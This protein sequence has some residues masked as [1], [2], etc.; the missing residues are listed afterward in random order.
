M[1]NK[2]EQELNN[3][4][5][6]LKSE[7]ITLKKDLKTKV[8]YGLTFERKTEKVVEEC[9]NKLPVLK[10][11]VGKKVETD[12]TK[13][14]N[15]LI[16]GDNYHSLQVLNYTHQNKVDFIYIDPPYNRGGD[17]IYN[18]DFIKKEDSYKHSMW[19]SFME[20]RLLLSRD[21]LSENGIIFISID[22][23]EF[24]PLKLLCDQIFT[25]FSSVG[26]IC[27]QKASGGGNAK[28]LVMGHEYIV[29]FS[30]KEN[31]LTQKN[32]KHINKNYKKSKNYLE[33]GGKIF[34]INDDII[35]KYFGKYPE[36]VE[37]RCEYEELLKYKDL[38][39]KKEIDEKIKNGE[40]ILRKNPNNPK[41]NFICELVEISDARMVLYSIIQNIFNS[42][43][44]DL[45]LDMG[46]AENMFDYPKPVNLIKI[47]LDS[48]NNKNS[49]V[50]DF[51]AGSGTTGHAVLELNKD[52]GNRQF[53][54][55]T[56]N[57]DEK[58]EHKIASDICYPR[59][60]KAIEGYVNKDKE[61][62]KGL[63]GNIRYFKT[64]FIDRKKNKD[65]MKFKITNVSTEIL[66]L[67][68]GIFDVIE[69]IGD[70]YS[71]TYKIVKGYTKDGPKVMGIYFDINDKKLD[72]MRKKLLKYKED[73]VAYIFSLS[74][75]TLDI[76][77]NDWLQIK[78]EPI[79]EKIL[80]VYEY[81][82]KLNKK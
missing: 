82:Y 10:E 48:T 23:H 73:K 13:P 69:E 39:T 66:C 2:T 16:E 35:R 45:L 1:A 12:K 57:G 78:I 62:I 7:I 77:H 34:F 60:Q 41:R 33:K 32:L 50:L 29:C 71:P 9:E 75:E 43:G 31:T 46:F 14:V 51:F 47:L 63:G 15:I 70:E 21:L 72:E 52:G 67:K 4:I 59:I 5:S 49:V 19:L 55:C 76:N 44:K 79:P 22:E 58:S 61:K 11:V 8:K 30:K 80:K 56:N 36:G 26:P 40:Y 54:L 3:L 37:R 65:E 25:D 6:E 28:K 38:N 18:D 81:V 42:E 74:D 64:T 68:E 17:F 24:A 20:K 53:I 27:W